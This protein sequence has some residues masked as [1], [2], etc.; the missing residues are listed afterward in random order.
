MNSV[1]RGSSPHTRGTPRLM[2]RALVVL[3]FI[4]AHAGNTLSQRRCPWFWP[5]HPRTR[6]EHHVLAGH[7]NHGHG[8]S[9]HT[10]GT[11]RSMAAQV[12]RSGFIPA[13]AGNTKRRSKPKSGSTVHPR[14]RGEHVGCHDEGQVPARFIP[15][16]AGNTMIGM[17]RPYAEPVHPRTRGEH[18]TNAVLP[19]GKGGSSPHTRGTQGPMR[20]TCVAVRFIPAHAGN[21]QEAEP[22]RRSSAVHPRTRGEHTLVASV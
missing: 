7:D 8:S 5:V 20:T 15:A 1:A 22:L 16:H 17:G 13:H 11:H 2:A 12:M 19:L 18:A 10:R 9:P 14:T 6:G 21:T 3:R 4:P